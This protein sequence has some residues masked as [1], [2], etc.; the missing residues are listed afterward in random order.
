MVIRS[1]TDVAFE[2]LGKKKKAITFKKLWE[3]VVEIMG[4]SETVATNKLA[5][6]YAN[7][8]LDARFA[9]VEDGKW[10]LRSRRTFNETHKDLSDILD[11]DDDEDE[12]LDEDSE[13][14]LDEG[15]NEEKEIFPSTLSD[16]DD[17]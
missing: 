13:G 5:T 2:L 10:D 7:L 14:D 6:F 9:L 12:F 4:Y 3:E 8:S 11:L 1:M 15:E 17:Y 16:E